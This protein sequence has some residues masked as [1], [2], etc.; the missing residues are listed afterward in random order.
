[1]C[2][3]EED[4]AHEAHVPHEEARRQQETERKKART[5]CIQAL[6][7]RVTEKV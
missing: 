2:C 5:K 1:V 7:G 3:P 4:C 6:E